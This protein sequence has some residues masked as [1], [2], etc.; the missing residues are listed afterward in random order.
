MKYEMTNKDD[1]LSNAQQSEDTYLSIRS[2][3][4]DAQKQIY[5]AVNSAMVTAY[6]QIGRLIYE[7][8]GESERAAY[9]KQILQYVSERL[10]SEFGNAPHCGA[11]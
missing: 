6:W 3:V 8:C 2:Y 11:N 7:A 5:S 1:T 4:I 10:T 9:G